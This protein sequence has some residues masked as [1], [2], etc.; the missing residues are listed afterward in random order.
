M[1]SLMRLRAMRAIAVVLSAI[2]AVLTFVTFFMAIEMYDYGLYSA[3]KKESVLKYDVVYSA[4]YDIAYDIFQ[5]CDDDYSPIIADPHA[6]AYAAGRELYYTVT[7]EDG[8]VCAARLVPDGEKI[9]YTFDYVMYYEPILGN[10]YYNE[11]DGE[12]TEEYTVTLDVPA[13]RSCRD[14]IYYADKFFS[15]AYKNRYNV[16]AVCAVSA[17]LTVLTYA[18]AVAAAGKR[19]DTD[20]TVMTFFDKIPFDVMLF[21][22][23]WLALLLYAFC[24]AWWYEMALTLIALCVSIFIG[25]ITLT[26]LSMTSVVRVKKRTF[27]KNNVTVMTVRAI[28]RLTVKIVRAVPMFWRALLIACGAAVLDFV[29]VVI[30]VEGEFP[31]PYIFLWIVMIAG[32]SFVA[33][34]MSRLKKGAERIASGELDYKIST[35]NLLYDFKRHAE[36]LNSIGDG[37][38][39]AVEERMKGERFKTE[40]ITNVSHDIKTP[41]TSIINYVYLLD[42]CGLE[43]EDA[44]SYVEVLKRQSEKLKK[45]TEDIVEASK[46]SSGVIAVDC[47]PCD[48]AILLA[49][50][51]GEYEERF[52]SAGLTLVSRI[53]EVPVPVFADGKLIFRIFDNLLGNALKYSLTG[54]RVHLL[55]AESDGYATASITNVSREPLPADGDELTERFVRGDASRHTDGSG[56]GLSIAK[57]LADLQG[58]SLT[59][60]TD[61]DFFKATLRM[62]TVANDNVC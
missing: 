49:Q 19:R 35:D 31:I 44:K 46:A 16:I 26:L 55:L 27:I 51:A 53:P 17:I 23:F 61:G 15:F 48:L 59:V 1:N 30:M 13:F 24:D 50:A 8:E 40:L 36:N 21:A 43:N 42:K 4:A 20:E 38:S 14:N 6:D 41:V 39:A 52:A 54:T 34:N 7:K 57:S 32:V 25:S 37:M 18:F 33:Y 28:W 62:Q 58:G 11:V 22:E 45:L 29:S 56:L 9:A 12:N 47:K 3:V 60:K 5:C 10:E 2:F